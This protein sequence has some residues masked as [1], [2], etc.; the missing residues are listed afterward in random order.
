VATEQKALVVP[1]DN[2]I[3]NAPL[4]A[5]INIGEL[6]INFKNKSVYTKNPEGAIIQLG[7]SAS[8]VDWE[9]TLTEGQTTVQPTGGYNVN[10]IEVFMNGRKLSK[11]EYVANDGVNVILN[12]GGIVDDLLVVSVW[13]AFTVADAYT[14]AQSDALLTAQE[15]LMLGVNQTWQDVKASRAIGAPYTNN[16]GKPIEVIVTV[17]NNTITGHFIVNIGG[18]SFNSAQ[19]ITAG[20]LMAPVS[21]IVPDGVT[22]SLANVIGVNT[23]FDWLEL[24]A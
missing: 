15:G 9:F 1:N 21:F 14:Q 2:T 12:D 4:P 10:Q 3:D 11:T 22:Y 20:Q 6:A 5:E 17:T 7:G 16:T 19:E 18:V 13:G 23:I 24:R 8:I